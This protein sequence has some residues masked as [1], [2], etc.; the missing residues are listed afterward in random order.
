MPKLIPL[1]THQIYIAE[2]TNG[3][4]MFDTSPSVS[5]IRNV[6]EDLEGDITVS[7]VICKEVSR[8]ELFTVQD[9]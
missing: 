4:I 7:V 3:E 8:R 9:T 6:C 2:A 1:Q 5:D